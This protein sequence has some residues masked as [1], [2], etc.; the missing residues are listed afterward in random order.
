L[1]VVVVAA[2]GSNDPAPTPERK[3]AGAAEPDPIAA[4]RA[5]REAKAAA[6][7]AEAEALAAQIDALAS[8]PDAVPRK[9]GDACKQMLDAYDAYMRK[10]L[11]GDMLTKWETGGNEMQLAAF[12]KACKTGTPEVAACQTH[13]LQAMSPK[14]EP[15]LSTIM[16]RCRDKFGGG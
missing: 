3:P 6:E 4:R 11:Q 9:L 7:K 8:L 5:Q 12:G 2:C 15:E 10:V 16:T 13:A 1:L 14:L